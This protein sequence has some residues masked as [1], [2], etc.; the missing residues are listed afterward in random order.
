MVLCVDEELKVLQMLVVAVVVKA[1]I[2]RF[3]DGAVHVLHLAI[4]SRMVGLGQAVF[5][6]VLGADLIE[7]ENSVAGLRRLSFSGPS[8]FLRHDDDTNTL[9]KSLPQ[10][11]D[12]GADGE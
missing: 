6:G 12:R 9:L 7:A 8:W 11:W 10:P 2:G 5:D 1:F 4:R 3:F